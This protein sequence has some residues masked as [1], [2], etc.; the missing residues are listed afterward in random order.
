MRENNR[1]CFSSIVQ[2]RS[3]ITSLLTKLRLSLLT[4]DV[5]PDKHQ[6]SPGANRQAAYAEKQRAMGRKQRSFWLTDDE[7]IAVNSLVEQI[8][9]EK[10]QDSAP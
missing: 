1:D 2:N 5:M 6:R 4:Q 7:A 10:L 9:A 3:A 8:R